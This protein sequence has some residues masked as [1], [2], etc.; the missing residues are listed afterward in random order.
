M[1]EADGGKT[2]TCYIVFLLEENEPNKE[3][4]DLSA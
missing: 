3:G 2:F 4:N 1:A